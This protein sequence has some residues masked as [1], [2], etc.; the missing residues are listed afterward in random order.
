[1]LSWLGA[2]IDQWLH[3][4][5]EAVLKALTERPM[6]GRELVK[7][8]AV[9]RGNCYPTLHSLE[10]RVLELQSDVRQQ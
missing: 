7:A 1:M 5:D 10:R 3:R 9:S 8:G 6:T 4:H 2:K